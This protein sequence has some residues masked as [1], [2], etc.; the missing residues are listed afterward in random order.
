V[1][2]ANFRSVDGK[3]SQVVS[4]PYA[5]NVPL[6]DLS[7][8]NNESRDFK[9][10]ELANAEAQKPFNLATDRMVRASLLRLSHDEH[11]LLLTLHH[12]VFDGWSRAILVRELAALYDAFSQG[13][14]SPLPDMPIQYTDFAV[15][16]NKHLQG[17]TLAKQLSYWKQQLDNA[18]RSLD[19]PT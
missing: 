2:R 6:T 1:L 9:V 10:R 7:N 17:K 18:P 8:S 13:K 4:P 3:P 5:V 14:P 12:I 19:L 11:V 16:Q 15:W